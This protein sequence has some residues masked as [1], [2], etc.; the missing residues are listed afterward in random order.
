MA[1]VAVVGVNTHQPPMHHLDLA[2]R[3]KFR[4]VRYDF[5]WLDIEVSPDEFVWSRFDEMVNGA[6]SRN[7]EVF[8]TLAYTPPWIGHRRSVPPKDRWTNF[9]RRVAER[10]NHNVWHWGIWN[11]PNSNGF[12]DG[13]MID[14]IDTLLIPA[15]EVLHR[16]NPANVVIGPELTHN[17]NWRPWLQAVLH[18]AG[19]QVDVVSHHIYHENGREV[20]RRLR[21]VH[22]IARKPIW[23]TETGLNTRRYSEAQQA[24]CIDQLLES[25]P[26]YD[27]LQ[28]VFLYQLV[29]EPSTGLGLLRDDLTPKPA[30]LVCQARL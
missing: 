12:W 22:D 11:E 7:L 10:Y 27:W 26:E 25:L 29:D 21:S 16:I 3:G 13:S 28:R 5:N 15:A 9:V 2:V 4:A 30:F 1:V 18:Y 24:I 14:Y 6:R 23:L 19:P 20:L 8:A 17:D